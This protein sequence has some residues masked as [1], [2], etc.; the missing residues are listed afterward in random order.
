MCCAAAGCAQPTLPPISAEPLEIWFGRA[1]YVA[2]EQPSIEASGGVRLRYQGRTIAASRLFIDM[3]AQRAAGSDGLR[4]ID[5]QGE[6]TGTAFEYF[7]EE[8]RG[9]FEGAYL[10][11]GP[12]RVWAKRLEIS[13][14]VRNPSRNNYRAI[15][16][17][18]TTCEREHPHYLISTDRAS[19]NARFR[20]T[21]G[22]IRVKLQD[23]TLLTLPFFNYGLTGKGEFNLPSPVYSSLTGVGL[24]WTERAPIQDRGEFRVSGSAFVLSRPETGARFAWNFAEPDVPPSDREETVRFQQ[25]YF[26]TLLEESPYDEVDRLAAKK[27]W[28]G[29]SRALNARAI[30]RRRTDLSVNKEWELAAGF[31]VD[32]GF[33]AG[34]AILRAGSLSEHFGTANVPARQRLALESEWANFVGRYDEDRVKG[35]ARG[36]TRQAALRFRLQ[37][38]AYLYE[39]GQEYAWARPGIEMILPVSQTTRFGISFSRAFETG[40]SPFL[41]DRIDARNEVRLRAETV[42]GNFRP[43][44]LV[45]FD[46]DRGDFYDLQLSFGL[47]QHCLEPFVF[48]RRSPGLFRIGVKLTALR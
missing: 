19:V 23:R 14:D 48:W 42:L 43:S 32:L 35:Y 47:T 16:A 6:L 31:R 27:L 25:G 8:K 3:A 1:K 38:S 39:G 40:S 20:L 37:M 15:D 11:T 7:Y 22:P 26:E 5:P 28:V 36:E 30:G 12:Y 44:L 34:E 29:L 45:K 13:P 4:L 2:A 9:W 33:G 21:A 41:F 18:V 10:E 24:T 46:A 17:A